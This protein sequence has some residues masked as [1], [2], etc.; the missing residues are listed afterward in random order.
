LN[1]FQLSI[2]GVEYPLEVTIDPAF[3]KSLDARPIP[4]TTKNLGRRL[5]Q[6]LSSLF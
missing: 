4:S 2:G 6:P 5:R 3:L 1:S